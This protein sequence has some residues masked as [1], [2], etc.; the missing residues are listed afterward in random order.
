MISTEKEVVNANVFLLTVD[1]KK[2]RLHAN[3]F[4]RKEKNVFRRNVVDCL[5]VSGCVHVPVCNRYPFYRLRSNLEY[6]EQN[7]NNKTALTKQPTKM[8]LN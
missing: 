5:S 6:S 7:N 8:I 2:K 4:E 1:S 3:V